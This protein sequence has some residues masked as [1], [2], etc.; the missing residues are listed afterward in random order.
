LLSAFR[1]AFEDP[2]PLVRVE[3][4]EAL[5]FLE[6]PQQEILDILVR[7]LQDKD[8]RAKQRAIEALERKG[9]A[10]KSAAPKLIE[11]LKGPEF[12][13]HESAAK[14]L[15]A[16]AGKDKEVKNVLLEAL[17][18]D[19]SPG[20]QIGAADAFAAL[21]SSGVEAIPI[22]VETLRKGT[23]RKPQQLSRLELS[24]VCALSEMGT[25]A[26]PAV[27]LLIQIL[28]DAA[29]PLNDRLLAAHAIGSI[30]IRRQEAMIAL[31]NIA[32][33]E[34]EDP[35]LRQVTSVSLE[36]LKKG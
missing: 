6:T 26:E 28:K 36:K 30:G 3:S 22:L 25:A 9:A 24:S 23:L 21:G 31:Q 4:F 14:T 35:S 32:R 17:Q 7:G 10:A 33:N 12:E 1:P 27:V 29:H 15:G 20:S 16:V 11:I 34:R 8:K 2:E 18:N 5:G 19:A 13:L